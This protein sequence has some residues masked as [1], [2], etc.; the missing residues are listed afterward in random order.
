MIDVKSGLDKN[1]IDKDKY[2]QTA[3]IENRCVQVIA[4]LWHSRDAARTLG[5]S[6]T[7]SSEAALL[8]GLALKWRWRKNRWKSGKP[9]GR[10][11]LICGLAQICW[12]KFARMWESGSPSTWQE[13]VRLTSFTLAVAAFQAVAGGS[14]VA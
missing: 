1:M 5:C 13:W 12:H 4:D 9:A 2:P 11:N 3:E 6:T 10:P 14:K 7:G 8:G